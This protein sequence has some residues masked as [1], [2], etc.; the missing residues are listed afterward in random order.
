M[1]FDD[2]KPLADKRKQVQIFMRPSIKAQLDA[3]AERD[4]LNRSLRRVSAIGPVPQSGTKDLSPAFQRW[5][6]F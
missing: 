2:P 4:H 5:V 6:R 1:N 3:I